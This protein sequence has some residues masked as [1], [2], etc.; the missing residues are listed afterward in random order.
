[1]KILY[2]EERKWRQIQNPNILP[3]VEWKIEPLTNRGGLYMVYTMH[4]KTSEDD[5]V[6]LVYPGT[7]TFSVI[8]IVT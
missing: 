5:I 3:C 6:R 1:M 4:K 8:T 7:V 2:P